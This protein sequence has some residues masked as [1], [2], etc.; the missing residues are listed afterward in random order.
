ML[1]CPLTY[2]I[3]PIVIDWPCVCQ[4]D[5][6][7]EGWLLMENTTECKVAMVMK[8]QEHH[9]ML[10]EKATAMGKQPKHQRD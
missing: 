9:Q 8:N 1:L 3:L 6:E 2:I 7:A 4:C 10:L 5:Q